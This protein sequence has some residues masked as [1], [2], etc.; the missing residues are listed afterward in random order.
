M[1]CCEWRLLH[2]LRQVD[3]F[4]GSVQGLDCIVHWTA[5][6]SAQLVGSLPDCAWPSA[7]SRVSGAHSADDLTGVSLSQLTLSGLALQ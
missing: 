7:V 5:C 6:V 4:C 2:R 3:C 1:S